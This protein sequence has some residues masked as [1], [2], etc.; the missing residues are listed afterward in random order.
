MDEILTIW[1]ITFSISFN[2]IKILYSAFVCALS[3]LLWTCE[4]IQTH[5]YPIGIPP[6]TRT[7]MVNSHFQAMCKSEWH[8]KQLFIY[9]QHAKLCRRSELGFCYDVSC[10]KKKKDLMGKD[11]WEWEH[12]T[13][14]HHTKTPWEGRN[15]GNL[16]LNNNPKPASLASLQI[17]NIKESQRETYDT[18]NVVKHAFVKSR[19]YVD[20]EAF[21]EGLWWAG[22]NVFYSVAAVSV[23][24][25]D[26]NE[27]GQGSCANFKM[28]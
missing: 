24:T 23:D 2:I 16:I 26:K 25:S 14:L 4:W 22:V 13:S 1:A 9:T 19:N 20:F 8:P 12:D 27:R 21:E 28:P 5:I 7:V 6:P 11:Q 18:A 10:K 17:E 15:W 3:L